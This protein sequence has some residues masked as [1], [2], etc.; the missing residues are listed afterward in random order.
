MA[1]AAVTGGLNAHPP[2]ARGQRPGATSKATKEKKRKRDKKKKH[3]GS[4]PGPGQRAKVPGG[5]REQR[6][7]RGKAARKSAR[8]SLDLAAAEA[9]PASN[10]P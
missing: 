2:T 5:Q 3:N 9:A 7:G 6:R 10:Q 1:V 4:K 8:K